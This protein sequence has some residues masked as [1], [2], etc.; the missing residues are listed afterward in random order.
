MAVVLLICAVIVTIAIVAI[1]VATIR[2]S[3]RLVR[4]IDEIKVLSADVQQWVV[5]ARLVTENAQGILTS[6]QET[7]QPLRRVAERLE[8]VG[9]RAASLS[10][11][12]LTELERPVF[13]AMAVTR[14]IRSGAA[15]FFNRLNFRFKQGRHAADGRVSS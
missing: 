11:A 1:A 14:G 10:E 9:D 13:N 7:V 5:Q 3:N 2:S 6:V 4:A 12:V 8:D 15:F